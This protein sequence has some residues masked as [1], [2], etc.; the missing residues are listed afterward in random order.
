M[1][2]FGAL[3]PIL[4]AI[5]ILATSCASHKV[6]PPTGAPPPHS[7]Y[8]V[9]LRAGW[10][11]RVVTPVIRSGGHLVRGEP[12]TI[13]RESR[14]SVE[15]PGQ[16][17]GAATI[18][19]KTGKDFIGYEVSIYSVK[20]QTG[21]GVRVVFRSAVINIG[22][23]KTARS[24]PIVPLFRSPQNARF[25]RVLHLAWGSHGDHE[26]A[27]L[28]AAREDSLDALT[29]AVESHPSAC[30][31]GIDTFCSWIPA[32]IAVIPEHRKG[33]GSNGQWTAAY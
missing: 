2:R 19:L 25:V 23:K 16:T 31:T 15:A 17:P 12:A 27:I 26:A 28:A 22:G 24:H 21:G 5:A 29:K 6:L 4:A 8:W 32:G 30:V 18:T 20:S 14:E 7:W 13:H 11:V 1:K 9:D 33:A 3:I 10:R